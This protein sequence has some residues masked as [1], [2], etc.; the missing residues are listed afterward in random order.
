MP[1][2]L[3]LKGRCMAGIRSALCMRNLRA[4]GDT[5]P[6]ISRREGFRFVW[7]QADQQNDHSEKKKP[8]LLRK[9]SEIK[10]PFKLRNPRSLPGCLYKLRLLI[11]LQFR[12]DPISE[13]D[14]GGV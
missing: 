10:R 3:V 7:S 6:V 4:P 2:P 5:A 14:L 8:C 12:L 1:E 11:Q 13:K 9:Q